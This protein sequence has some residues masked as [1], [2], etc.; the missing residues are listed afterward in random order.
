M[1]TPM[2]QARRPGARAS[3]RPVRAL[4]GGYDLT[5]RLFCSLPFA[6]SASSRGGR[7][8]TQAGANIY[9]GTKAMSITFE[10]IY[11]NGVLKPTQPLP[12]KEG[13]QVQVTV[14]QPSCVADKT[15]GMIGWAG[16]ADTFNRLLQEC[17][18][19]RLER[20]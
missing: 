20:Q 11:E 9:L 19:D 13:E 3:H 18:T 12:L 16:D 2:F 5:G 7:R 17:E 15:H 10:A 8:N 14:R 6:G 1:K 4:L